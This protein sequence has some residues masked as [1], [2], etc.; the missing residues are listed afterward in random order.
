MYCSNIYYT[1]VL[2]LHGLAQG[3]KNNRKCFDKIYYAGS[4]EDQLADSDTGLP[5]S[6]HESKKNGI[7]MMKKL[8]QIIRYDELCVFY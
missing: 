3:L 4:K 8:D 5:T 6:L 7:Y 2:V 1:P